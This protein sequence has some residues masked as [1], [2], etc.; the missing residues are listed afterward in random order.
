MT[1]GPWRI[2]Q[3]DTQTLAVHTPGGSIAEWPANYTSEDVADAK[4][5][6]AAPE[7]LD[8]AMAALDYYCQTDNDSA[9]TAIELRAAIAKA[10]K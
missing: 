7:L 4:L 8:A 9:P 10:T 5:I 2:H 1:T 6:A 3:P